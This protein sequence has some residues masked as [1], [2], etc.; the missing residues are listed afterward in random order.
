MEEFVFYNVKEAPFSIHGLY[1]P[2]VEGQFQR[3]PQS[4][5]KFGNGWLPSLAFNTAGGR[6]RFKTNSGRMILRVLTKHKDQMFHATPLM[7]AGFDV[8]IDKA[9]GAQFAGATKPEFQLREE[10]YDAT[11]WFPV[12]VDK[13]ITVN[14][15]LYGDVH[16]LQIG[17]ENG[18]SLE[19]HTP[20]KHEKPIVYYGSSITQGGCA[21]RPGKSYQA[22]ISRK[23]DCDYINLGFSGSARAEDEVIDYLASLDMSAFVSDYDHNA[24]NPEHLKNTH[25]KMYE[26]IREKH[27][28]I[29][30]FMVSKPDFKYTADDIERRCI[31]MESYLEAYRKGDKNVYFIDGSAFFNGV[32]M[33]DY[34]IDGCHPTDDGFVRMADYIGDVLA[35]V[36]EL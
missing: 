1:E 30:Y 33:G 24:P 10:G 20:Y 4:V 19:A 18:S 26:K 16:D 35:K 22:I 3:M 31:I 27:P 13:E 8:Y 9:R 15:P 2:T 36:M 29:P 34:T 28:D 32:D 12:G 25:H 17:L 14:F 5:A 11:F 21:S 7:E 23:Y 6:V